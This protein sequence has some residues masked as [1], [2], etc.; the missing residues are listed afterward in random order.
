[1]CKGEDD[2]HDDDEMPTTGSTTTEEIPDI[3]PEKNKGPKWPIVEGWY[4]NKNTKTK[5]NV[6]QNYEMEKL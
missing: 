5:S 1:M 4:K 6:N 3:R 2:D